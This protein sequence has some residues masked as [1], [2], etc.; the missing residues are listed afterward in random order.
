MNDVKVNQ[1]RIWNN[2]K[3]LLDSSVFAVTANVIKI[4]PSSG[5]LLRR[6]SWWVIVAYGSMER[7]CGNWP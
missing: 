5:I 3:P 7:V 2:I 4:L 1:V 6:R